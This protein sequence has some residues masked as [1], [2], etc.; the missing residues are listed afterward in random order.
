MYL[1]KKIRR[2]GGERYESLAVHS[3]GPDHDNDANSLLIRIHDSANGM[4]SDGD[5]WFIDGNNEPGG[6]YEWP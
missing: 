1:R 3:Y 2:M 6:R 4:V 5:V